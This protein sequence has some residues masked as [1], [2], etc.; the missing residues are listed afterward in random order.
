[1]RKPIKILGT[2]C[3]ILLMMNLCLALDLTPIVKPD[4]LRFVNWPYVFL[5]LVNSAVFVTP[6]QSSIEKLDTLH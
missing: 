1:M 6:E 2:L 4:K 3:M 5:F